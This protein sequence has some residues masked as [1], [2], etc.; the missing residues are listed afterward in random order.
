MKMSSRIPVLVALA[1]ACL[2]AGCSAESK[3]LR[4]L[5]RASEFRKSGDV[6]RAR[7][8]Y[9]NVL[10]KFPD[11]VTANEA[12]ATIWHERGATMRAMSYL[13][14][15]V[16]VAPGNY[17]A[18]I[19]RARLLSS[20]GVRHEARREV[21]AIL[22]RTA[23]APEALAV[24]VETMRG[25]DEFKATEEMLR[26]FPDKNTPW[27]HIA[28]A[29]LENLRGDRA[30]AKAALDRAVVLDPKSAPAHAALGLLQ[31]A[32]NNP[33]AAA[34]SLKTSAELAPLR[35]PLRL[36]Y[37]AYL[38]QT[39]SVP[40]AI[41][42]IT[43][44]TK[45]APDAQH[46]WRALAQVALAEKRHDDALGFLGKALALDGSDYEAQVLRARVWQAQGDLPKAIAE[47]RRIGEVFQ[48]LGMEKPHLGMALLQANDTAGAT[49]ALEQAL[50]YF[51]DNL[52][53]VMLVAQLHLKSGQH[54]RVVAAMAGVLSRRPDLIQP[55]LLL[56]ESSKALGKLDALIAAFQQ[57]LAANPKSALLH[58][59]LGLA[60]WHQSKLPEVRRSLE[61]AVELAP[62]FIPANVDLGNLDLQEKRP[63]DALRR[64]QALTNAAPKQAAG[65]L[66]AARVHAT[67]KRWAAAE[68][69]ATEAA[70]LDR[71][72]AV[73]YGVIAE[74]FAARK[75]APGIAAM[76]DAFLARMPA[77]DLGALRVAAQS[78]VLIGEPERGRDLYEKHLALT[79]NSTIVL[80]NL[81]NLYA[82]QLRQTDRALE[83]ARKARAAAP[84][85]PA[86]ADTLGWI[87]YRRK[88][89]SEALPLIEEA[90]K[91]MAG[92]P[93][94]QYHLG[95]VNRALGKTE[96]ALAAL[97][98]AA[99]APGDFAG[100][101]DAKQVLAEMEKSR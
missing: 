28:N 50:A 12:L 22:E 10:Q 61:Q 18:R 74:S 53:I 35:S 24:L 38:A 72:Q 49:T 89:Y 31:A 85:E 86:I 11:D 67:E 84:G 39:G 48:G 95:L 68:E 16:G 77:D 57:N 21:L 91:G 97:R 1:L 43:E 5:E 44:I 40:A 93:E 100:K 96:P 75:D 42:A 4:Q 76:V 47:Y 99:A 37:P 63:A 6:E 23:V 7:I 19:K 65:P 33:T 59:M 82:E 2:L 52:E 9:Q 78:F 45:Q 3:R 26:N 94:V 64:A 54:D 83:L 81:A 25:P 34:A 46:A 98:L 17:E 87:H 69:A 71:T 70:R 90:A 32:M 62:D 13:T 30:K 73:A 15:L 101:A 60:Y 80:N 55:Y 41:T 79:P 56:I 36:A 14:K 51:P 29:A 8:E 66:L 27:Y 58:Y 20:L 88:E 92:N